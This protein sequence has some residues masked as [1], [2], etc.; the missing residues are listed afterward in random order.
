MNQK[1]LVRLDHGFIVRAKKSPGA[2]ALVDGLSGKRYTFR[3]TLISALLLRRQLLDV[4]DDYIG[5]MLPNGAGSVL[6]VLAVM[7]AGKVPVMI[8]FA[9]GAADNCAYAQEKCGFKTIITAKAMLEKISCPVVPG[10][11][12]VE[13]FI[14]RIGSAAKVH[15]LMLS[16]LPKGLLIRRLGL[17]GIDETAAVLFTSGSEKQPKAV[18]LTHRNI[19]S[20]IDEFYKRF[21]FTDRDIILSILPFF[22]VFGYTVHLWLPLISGMRMICYPSPLEYARV[23]DLIREEQVTILVGTPVF[24]MGYVRKAKPGDFKSLWLVIAGADTTPAWLF[25]TFR[26]DHQLNICEGYGTTETSPVISVNSPDARKEGSI[27]QPLANL[28]LRIVDIETGENLPVGRE[29]RIMVKGPSVMEGYFDDFE[30]TSMRLK[31]GWYDTGDIGLL[32][33]DGFLWHKGRL[34]RF[35][36]IGGEMVSMVRT[37]SVLVRLLPD[38]VECC[39][40]EIPDFK[41]GARLV[42][43]VSGREIDTEEL[44]KACL[45]E[46]PAIAVPKTYLHFPELPKMGSGKIDFRRVT[47]MVK[48]HLAASQNKES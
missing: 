38:D 41:K 3:K 17:G 39:V 37:E 23:V 48:D 24:L 33:E 13:D 14:A 42:A 22:H 16:T 12:F 26:R 28:K 44:Q 11:V 15:A 35:V 46:L 32:D 45:K 40:V 10:M 9:T 2:V 1:D 30:E 7:L 36:K 43:V 8:N 47:L 29:G 27:G 19:A 34:K 20:N 31:N 4:A 21:N 6:S 25:E 18:A 5:V